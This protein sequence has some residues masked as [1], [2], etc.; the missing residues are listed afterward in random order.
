M[1]TQ[2]RRLS[3]RISDRL[4]SGISKAVARTGKREA[5]LVREALDL[6]LGAQDPELTCFTLA[7]RARLIGCVRAVPSDLSTNREYMNGF[8]LE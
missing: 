1:P 5:D 8:G 2:S 3:V 4:Y 7:K 6:Y